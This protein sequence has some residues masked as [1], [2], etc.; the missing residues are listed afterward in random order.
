MDSD[1]SIA[2][3]QKFN[4]RAFARRI[5]CCLVLLAGTGIEIQYA[6]AD[7]YP[8]P[9]R[10]WRQIGGLIETPY[11][12]N[13]AEILSSWCGI[14]VGVGYYVPGAWRLSNGGI[15]PNTEAAAQFDDRFGRLNALE[16]H[17]QKISGLGFEFT[18]HMYNREKYCPG[19]GTLSGD[20]LYNVP[21]TCVSAPACPSG[22]AYNREGVC[23]I[24]APD[25]SKNVGTCKDCIKN[26][27]NIGI[28]NKFQ[29]E[30]DYRGPGSF[31]LQFSRFYNSDP[32]QL[33]TTFKPA[34][35]NNNIGLL[36]RSFYDR[37]IG[38][39]GQDT[40]ALR[41]D[42]KQL[43]FNSNGFT[44]V[45][46]QSDVIDRLQLTFNP[47]NGLQ[48]GWKYTD[49]INDIV[50]NYDT[51]RKLTSITNREGLTQTLSYDGSNRLTIVTDSFGRTLSFTYDSSNRVATM[52]DP[53][54]GVYQYAYDGNNNLTSV[55]NPDSTV[56]TYHYENTSFVN[57]LTGIT[58]ENISRFST[59]QYDT[60]GRATS[61][62]HAGGADQATVS[63]GTN[64]ATVTDTLGATLSYDFSIA[65]NVPKRNGTT[66]PAASGSGTV[67]DVRTYDANGNVAA[68]TDFNGNRTNYTYD[69]ARNLET[70][71]VEGLTSGGSTTA[72]TRT[73]ST[74]WHSTFRLPIVIAEPLRKTT[75]VYNGDS[76]ASCGFKAD[77]V[78]LVPGVLCSKTVQA[79][80]DTTGAAGLSPTVTGTARV[81]TYTYNVNGSV[82]TING[83]R[84]DVTDV[85]TYT[86]YANN[87]TCSGASAV[88][89][90]G[91][92]ETIT[93]AAGHV[94][95]ITDYNAHGQPLS[96]TDPNGLVTTLA[97]D[98]RLRLTSRT[99][100]SEVTSYLY[101]GVGQLTTVTLPDTSFLSYTYD[102]AHRLTQIADNLG[103]KIVYTLDLMG[104]RTQE[105]VFDP[106]NTLA[107]T[108]SRVYNSLNRL[109][110]EI[111][112][113]SQTTAYTYDNQGNVTGID[114]PLS[115]TTDVTVN[116]YDAL[117]RLTQMTN[118]LSGVVGYGYNGVDQLT[119]VTDP[120]TLVTSYSYD[121]LNNLN[122]QASP[123]TG[124]TAN[125]YDAAGN[126]L[127]STDAKSQVTTYTYDVLNRVA[128]I[129]YA[130]GV[131]H[132]YTYDQGTNGKGRLTQITE[133]NSVT[134]Y[135]Y[136]P[137]GRLLSETRTINGVPYATAYGYDSAGRMTS[138][139]YPSGRVV[140]YTLDSLGHIQ[141]VAT[142][143]DSTTQTVV[144][145]V[146]Y[147]PFGPSAGFT[148]GNGQTYSRG[149][150]QDGRIS[151]YTL[152][153][154]S[155]A[156]GYDTA[157][158]ITSLTD[159]VV[160]A[161]TNT[162][163][164]DTLDR[165]TAFTG[166]ST[167]QGY[168]FDA[169]GNRLT[170]TV[171]ANTDT[172]TYSGT[173]NKLSTI[174]GSTNR[175]Y[176]YDTNGSTTGDTAN[177]YA[178]DTRGRMVQTTGAG[179]TSSYQLNS[180][181]QRIRKTNTAGDTIYHYDA[182]GRLISETSASGT[183]QREYIYLGDTPVAVIQ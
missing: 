47:I 111:G 30:I 171:G 65:I 66:Q 3:T 127:T 19:G 160:P 76:G 129:V 81:W 96:I 112:A 89:C 166:P 148:F 119:S 151:S 73:I 78:T 67:T 140:N 134:A 144:S 45:F 84:T 80:T 152:A 8:A 53:N 51:A 120:R 115:G 34:S 102:A 6:Q 5:L 70:A 24:S 175:T 49:S 114:G 155:L 161:N 27:I 146:A 37:R 179:G 2:K 60:Q 50:E 113:S 132:S 163:G 117:N 170:K 118:P 97:Y 68:S 109:T 31:P 15:P 72:A 159:T 12:K 4:V 124:T 54:G 14:V 64:S 93:N 172:Y 74:Q 106:S 92:V 153:T 143:K 57:A 164:Y 16:I 123:D 183:P 58:D 136:D 110:Q 158:R 13:A 61:T 105:Q 94:T 48:T 125:T 131:T 28:G 44:T 9:S 40:T 10:H 63:Y 77:G 22:Q 75:L 182:Q 176:G 162:Y 137:Q 154:Q 62:T 39:D 46:P 101:D 100:G 82:L 7:S 18:V 36:W 85:T 180:V 133:P 98:T 42:G 138:V 99:V 32:T 121:G 95:S 167:N 147:R 91:Q 168:T 173:S 165:L 59:Y 149:F 108:R 25:I 150:D 174:A 56:R 26:P 71:R 17:C 181:G 130:G 122:Q 142:T 69:L 55:I 52:T 156:V 103:N 38:F 126:L 169:T 11:G 20:L 86:Y 90:R 145:S 116:A 35:I 29:S 23:A 107:Q 1:F 79:T 33:N 177:T 135:A 87:A 21:L 43:K 139:T 157:S 178:Y 128:S 41:P 104:N 141:S 83:P 88:G